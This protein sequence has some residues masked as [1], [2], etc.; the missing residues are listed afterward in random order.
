MSKRISRGAFLKGAAGLAVAAGAGKLLFDSAAQPRAMPPC[1]IL[2]PSMK[3][4]HELRDGKFD[5]RIA[6]PSK[7]SRAAVTIIGG[8]ISGLSAAW[9]LKK[10]GVS[11]I[12]LIELEKQVGGNSSSSSNNVS[13]F[14]WGA[15][16]VPLPNEEST[17][18]RQLF[19]ELGIITS[20]DGQ[21]NAT[22]NDLYLCHDPQERLYKD[23]S[24]QEGLVPQ[25]GL[26]P[27]DKTQFAKFFALVKEYRQAKGTDG[28]PAFAIPLDLSSADERFRKLDRISM[29]Q[30]LT[31]NGFNSKPLLWY[32]NYCCR[33]DYGARPEHVSAWAGIHY[34]AGRRGAANNAEHNSVLTWPEGNGFLVRKL[35][36]QFATK[37]REGVA[38]VRVREVDGACETIGIDI[39]SGKAEKFVSETVILCCPRFVASRLAELPSNAD[40]TYSPW[41]VGNVTVK[42]IPHAR[43]VGLAWDNVSYTSPSLGY[44]VATHQQ[45]TTRPAQTVLTYYLPLTE[46]EPGIARRKLLSLD[47]KEWSGKIIADLESMHAGIADEIISIDLWPWGHGM[48]RPSVGY[49]WG[50]TRTTM[51]ESYGKILFAHS[52]MSGISNFEEAQYR[53]IEA[54]EEAMAI[55]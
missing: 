22:Y 26:Q 55:I 7:E 18:V 39:A 47:A 16:Y 4:G 32:V 9:W 3:I 44:V 53:G 36:E 6:N 2:G 14:P 43:G 8:G 42:R 1:R 48:I 54:A 29:Q 11:D 31:E 38:V 28:K 13:A 30:W 19:K 41:L 23:G 33:D 37:V 20:I 49:I 46:E 10:N 34:F 40:L 27:E 50:D 5:H 24:F 15:H 45:I 51:K 17:H 21:G 52:D 12:R 35:K 25:R